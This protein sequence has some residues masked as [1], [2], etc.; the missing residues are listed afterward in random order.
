M[1][2]TGDA[3]SWRKLCNVIVCV[4]IFM[5]LLIP[6]KTASAQEPN[7]V[8]IP[9]E[10][11]HDQKSIELQGLISS[12]TLNIPIPQNWSPGEDN[13]IEIQMRASPL[14]DSARSSLTVSLN[15][16]L[17]ISD[18]VRGI[19]RTAQRIPIP[20]SALMKGSNMLN[21]TG[22][23]YLPEDQQTNCQNWDDPSRWLVIEPGSIFHL[24]FAREDTP[25]DLASFPQGFIEPLETYLPKEA[26]KQTLFV[27][28]EEATPDDLTSVSTI[29]YVLGSYAGAG[30]N[31]HPE[32]ISE[33]QFND[34]AAINRNVI[35]I[36]RAP[37]DLQNR[38]DQNKDFIELFSSPWGVGN[39]VMVIGD[40]D[41]QDGFTPASVFSD[42]ARRIFLQGNVA[43]VQHQPLPAPQPFPNDFTFEDL[44]Y[45]DRTVRG[46]GQQNL[47]YRLY[48]PYN[49]ELVQVKLNLGLV[50]SPDLDINNSSFTLYLNGFSVAG[51]LPSPQNSAT[52]PIAIGLPDRRLKPGLNFI[53]VSF[54]LHIPRGSC[55]LALESVWATLLN[56]SSFEMSYRKRTPTPSLKNFPL[57][58]SDSPGSLLVIPDQYQQNDLAHVSQLSYMMGRVD[59]RVHDPPEV[60]T[61]GTFLAQ[62]SHPR[63]VIL[64]G[65]PSDNPV[66]MGANDLLPQPF[67]SDGH[68][69]QDG[70]GVQLPTSD[71][72]ASLGLLQIL[73][74]P[75]V[76]G[77]T[78]LVLTGNDPQ[79][80]E[81]T[82]NAILDPTLRNQFNGNL[83]VVG[84][85]NR[86]QAAGGL[87]AAPTLQTLFQQI[88]DAGNI[89]IVGPLLQ[90]YG[91]DFMTPAVAIG[92][93]LL[94]T[95]LVAW[96]SR[97]T[98]NRNAPTP[99]KTEKE[100]EEHE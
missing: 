80:L 12:Q 26:R 30:D 73:P 93:A 37:E 32:I 81:W 15:N 39:A 88:A 7:F 62:S 59:S 61:A 45:L 33:T 51:I 16:R 34:R 72:D 98:R 46:I 14:L 100:L 78:V 83:M 41:R 56:T 90:K 85:A 94:L 2:I 91:Q 92:S 31:W 54:D 87:S 84:S 4:S 60:M 96:F 77:G 76:R 48:I 11:F 89:P 9:L 5:S 17:L 18:R 40:H 97:V 19:V 49:I 58:F 63:N 65:L 21:I 42:P 71:Q 53:R 47:I 3:M 6:Q 27:L 75:W 64:V 44:G 66:T 25:I 52:E 95:V 74:S 8:E 43:Y 20:A 55:E 69:L 22:T 82:W 99:V 79:G 57:P 24:S 10:A 86:S 23:L 67:S 28:P 50:H 36:G 68:S 38:A 13:W 1:G 70:Y 35:F 29:S